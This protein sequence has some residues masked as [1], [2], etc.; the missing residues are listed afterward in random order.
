MPFAVRP[1]RAAAMR[2]E[3]FVVL[4]PGGA[5]QPQLVEIAG[6]DEAGEQ[7]QRADADDR[8]DAAENASRRRHRHHVA[9]ADG[10][11]GFDRPPHRGWYRGKD[12]R[13]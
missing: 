6:G 9:V 2:T 8:D 5:P 1:Q 10:G 12:R 7:S 3:E 4:A 13:L 11:D